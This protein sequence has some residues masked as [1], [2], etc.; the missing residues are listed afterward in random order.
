MENIQ[1]QLEAL[2]RLMDLTLVSLDERVIIRRGA[3]IFFEEGW[4][5]NY[6]DLGMAMA[7]GSGLLPETYESFIS[8]GH[9]KQRMRDAGFH[10]AD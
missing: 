3:N 2:E 7:A 5:S 1:K 4:P 9:Y 6:F 8:M 10:V